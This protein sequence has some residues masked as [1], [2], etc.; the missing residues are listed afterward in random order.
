MF[1]RPLNGFR[2]R[3]RGH[4]SGHSAWKRF[5][6]VPEHEYAGT[7]KHEY[8]PAPFVLSCLCV[9]GSRIQSRICRVNLDCLIPSGSMPLFFRC[10][11]L[12][13]VTLTAMEVKIYLRNY[14]E[15][16][17]CQ[18]VQPANVC[19]Q[20]LTFNPAEVHASCFLYCCN[21]CECEG[22]SVVEGWE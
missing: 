7:A 19:S 4:N 21:G 18:Q 6:Y 11:L 13:S 10:S 15:T 16:L 3:L 12:V 22:Q 14:T 2:M 1:H 8:L 9:H 5:R 20:L 17:R